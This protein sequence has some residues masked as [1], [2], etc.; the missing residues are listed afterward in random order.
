MYDEKICNFYANEVHLGVTIVPFVAN[1]I[2]EEN[3]ICTL[4]NVDINN[5]VNKVISKINIEDNLKDKILEINWNK[6]NLVGNE[7]KKYLNNELENNNKIYVI[8]NGNKNEVEEKN[9]YIE[10]I[11]KENMDKTINVVNCFEI[12][13]TEVNKALLKNY[14]KILNSEGCRYIKN[15]K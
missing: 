6:T 8:I 7:I 9:K 4:L 3:K 15:V 12:E 2:K 1:K 11:R 5:E 13:H 14:H 10:E